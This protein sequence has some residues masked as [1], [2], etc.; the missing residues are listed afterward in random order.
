MKAILMLII[1]F[2]VV[3][4]ANKMISLLINTIFKEV[5]KMVLVLFVLQESYEPELLHQK[6]SSSLF[7][8]RLNIRDIFVLG[9]LLPFE[10]PIF[11]IILK[12]LLKLIV[13][14]F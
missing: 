13:N 2:L 9:H 11:L 14:L 12:C 4:Q 3:C 10:V 1:I 7:E 6:R 8:T 5:D